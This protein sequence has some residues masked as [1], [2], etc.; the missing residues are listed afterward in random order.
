MRREALTLFRNVYGTAPAAAA[1][2]P[3][4]VNLI[5]EHT[6]YNGGPVLPIAVAV[7]TT[8][9]TGRGGSGVIEVVSAQEP[10]PQRIEWHGQM[11]EGSWAYVVG[12][13]RELWNAELIPA[14]AG[15]RIA[16]ASDVPVGAGLS[17]SAALAVATARALGAL[18]GAILT[19]RKLA[20][21]AFRAEH[22]HIGVRRGI[23]D[24]SISAMGKKG[25]ALLLECAS[26]ATKQ[27]PF[28]APLLLVD[29]GGERT[30]AAVEY[31]KRRAECEAAVTRLKVEL[32][33]LIWLASWPVEWLGRLKKAL[34]EPLRSRAVHV[35][36]ETAR[37]RFAAQLLERGRLRRFGELLYE[38]HES[39]RRQY[40]C[41]TPELDLVVAAAKK[42]GALGARLTG[43]GWGGAAVVL[44]GTR[45]RKGGI[46]AV[47]EAIR[48]A[49][50][51]R[52]GR[53]P[54]ITPLE[55]SGGVKLERV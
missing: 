34:P 50:R 25:H 1:S 47:G 29:T 55:A 5:G 40:E 44:P 23:M 42:A 43:G 41:S 4:R 13:M 39:L 30:L 9:A 32:P 14:N 52:F 45:H 16:V 27:I 3:G 33:E 6:D 53:D 49:F 37:V 2:A 24:Q 19:P 51:N 28:Q 46:G 31:N 20:G 21:V 10:G 54:V 38:S 48:R 22:D 35:I 7:R 36:S 11:P 17:S 8:V 26:L 12:V 15:A 18:F